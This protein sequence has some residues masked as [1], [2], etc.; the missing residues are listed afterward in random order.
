MGWR[1]LDSTCCTWGSKT[2]IFCGRFENQRPVPAGAALASAPLE[3]GVGEK[4]G[5][6]WCIPAAIHL[7]EG[8][9]HPSILQSPPPYQ[10]KYLCCNPDHKSA[11]RA[12]PHPEPEST[13]AETCSK[14]RPICIF[15][16]F[17][18]YSRQPFCP[19]ATARLSYIGTWR[20]SGQP[21]I[22][23]DMV[24]SGK[25]FPS[26]CLPLPCLNDEYNLRLI[27]LDGALAGVSY[28]L[29]IYDIQF[30]TY[31]DSCF[32]YPFFSH[33]VYLRALANWFSRRYPAAS[34]S[35]WPVAS[36]SPAPRADWARPMPPTGAET[37]STGG[38][39]PQ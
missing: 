8:L 5:C 37:Y 27:L 9:C 13:I 28:I 29:W 19:C 11:S 33:N 12:E 3:M 38:F 7:F 18:I 14:G 21:T 30:L 2:R 34:H 23:H 32:E 36:G 25:L 4:V 20:A 1:S 17:A 26:L 16:P 35:A 15:S 39:L 6:G 10:G 24:V 22:C 31:S